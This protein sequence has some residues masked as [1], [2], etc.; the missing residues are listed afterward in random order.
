LAEASAPPVDS[1]ERDYPDRPMIAPPNKEHVMA[2]KQIM[3]VVSIALIASGAAART[4]NPDPKLGINSEA[5]ADSKVDNKKY[6]IAYDKV[7][8]SRLSEVECKTK[9]EWAKQR[10]DVDRMLRGE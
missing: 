8:G 2:Y 9:A 1:A 3:V 6:C 10:V 4:S 5:P 7:V